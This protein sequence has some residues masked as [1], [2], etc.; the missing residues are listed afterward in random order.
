[1]FI[2]REGQINARTAGVTP[3]RGHLPSPGKM[4][5]FWPILLTKSVML[6]CGCW[7]MADLVTYSPIPDTRS[8]KT[9]S[10]RLTPGSD[11]ELEPELGA[12][13]EPELLGA[14]LPP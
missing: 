4:L 8:V 12:E 9:S 3:P 1:M 11:P 6:S 10:V 13:L 5:W 7:P 14:G 2:N